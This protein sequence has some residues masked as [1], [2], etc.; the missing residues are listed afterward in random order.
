MSLTAWPS[1]TSAGEASPPVRDQQTPVRNCEPDRCAAEDEGAVAG[2]TFDPIHDEMFAAMR[3]GGATPNGRSFLGR[4]RDIRRRGS[5]CLDPRRADRC[6]PRRSTLHASAEADLRDVLPRIDVPTLLLYGELDQRSP[7]EIAYAMHAAIPGSE[8]TV[9]PGVG[10]MSNL[11]APA[12]FNAAV[13]DF[14][15]RVE[16]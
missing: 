12:V 2:D 3:G 6:V 10:H 8:L 11:E 5:P 15:A 16:S 14:L 13:R 7:L 9:L 4:V 1:P